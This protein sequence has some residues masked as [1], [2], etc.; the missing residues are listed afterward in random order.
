MK[1]KFK[2][3]FSPH[4][5]EEIVRL[6][7]RTLIVEDT[8]DVVEARSYL[9]GRGLNDEAI[10]AFNFGYIPKRAIGHDWRG[11]VIMPLYDQYNELVVLTSRDF[12][13]TSKDKRPHLHEQFNKKRYLYGLNIAKKKIIEKNSVIVVEGQFDTTCLHIHGLTNTVGVLGSAFTFDHIALLRRYCQNIFLLF[14]NDDSGKSNLIRAVNLYN[15]EHLEADAFSTNLY[16]VFFDSNYKDPDELVRSK[17]IDIL[18]SAI[19]D[20]KNN[21]EINMTKVR[22]WESFGNRQK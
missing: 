2:T 8:E 10:E 1:E 14:D 5:R 15:E 20:A 18:K 9:Y 3:K 11:R 12:R 21:R 22:L 6:A 13:A 16:P 4:E 7:H 19:I 17:G